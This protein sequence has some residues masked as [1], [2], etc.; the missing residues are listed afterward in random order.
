MKTLIFTILFC[1]T[2]AGQEA[3]VIQL[4]PQDAAHA[5]ATWERLQTAQRDW[6]AEQK[7]VSLKYLIVD[8]KDP[9]ASDS[10]FLEESLTFTGHSATAVTSGTI[11]P[12][13]R[14]VWILR[15]GQTEIGEKAD[16]EL[17]QAEERAKRYAREKRVRRGFSSDTTATPEFPPKFQFSH[18]FKYLV[19]PKPE[20]KV[21]SSPW[22]V[23]Y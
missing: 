4:S 10:H 11:Y 20:Q 9:E 13:F 3:Y 16:Q 12:P 21:Y 1:L 23:A 17:R 22:S 18:D 19:P 14:N 15:D 2:A 7:V 5:Q 8:S 6:E